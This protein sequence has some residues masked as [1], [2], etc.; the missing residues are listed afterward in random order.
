MET[1]LRAC[2]VRL[3]HVHV[4]DSNR[5]HPGAG[6][7]DFARIIATLR[8][9]NYAG[10]VSAEILPQPDVARAAEQTIRTMKPLM[11]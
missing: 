6:H 2:G 7:I 3:F 4:A 9:M 11:K 10:W 1:S 5:W 8:E